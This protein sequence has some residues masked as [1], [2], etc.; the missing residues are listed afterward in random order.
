MSMRFLTKCLL[1]SILKVNNF[2]CFYK[3][4]WPGDTYHPDYTHP[5]ALDWWRTECAE[6]YQTVKY[7]ALWIVS[8]N[9]VIKVD[10]FNV[11]V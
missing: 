6:F 9:Y 2:F 8:E 4:V 3:Q 1:T 5:N 11:Q 10:F 7:D